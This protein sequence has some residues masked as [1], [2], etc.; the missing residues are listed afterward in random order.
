M[1]TRVKYYDSA[2]F[3]LS[4]SPAAARLYDFLMPETG[5]PNR[6]LTRGRAFNAFQKREC[7][8]L[9]VL[10]I[11]LGIGAIVLMALYVRGLGRM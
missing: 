9:D 6:D 2:V 7:S 11:L 1:I 10:F 8:M 5:I 4:P 3:A